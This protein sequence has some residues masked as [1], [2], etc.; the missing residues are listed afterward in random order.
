MVW[1][2]GRLGLE[3]CPVSYL[4]GESVAWLEDFWAQEALGRTDGLDHWPARRVDAFLVLKA[5]QRKLEAERN[6]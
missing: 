5:E 2:A 1:I 3:T 6:A 4:T